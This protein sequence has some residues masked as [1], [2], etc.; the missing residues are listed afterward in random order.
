[1]PIDIEK[2]KRFR[3]KLGWTQE[4]AAKAAGLANRQHWN[5]IETGLRDN[6]TV[7]TLEKVAMALG[8][9]AKDLLI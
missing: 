1:M 3:E 6:L 4:Q 8:V 2:I 5:Q 7:D 9:K